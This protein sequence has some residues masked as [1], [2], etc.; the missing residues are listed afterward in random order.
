MR[1]IKKYSESKTHNEI[2][3]LCDKYDI[4]NYTINEDGSIDVDG[5]VS[6]HGNRLKELPLTFNKVSGDFNISINKLTSLEG[7]PKYVG[8]DFRCVSNKLTSLKY[9]PKYVG[10]NFNC[11][12]NF[13]TSLDSYPDYVGGIFSCTDN[14]ISYIYRNFIKS[15]DNIEL[16]NEFKIIIG[17]NLY[18]N[19]LNAYM[20]TNNIEND[21]TIEIPYY[22]I[23]K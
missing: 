8:V 11:V 15:V 3:V 4:E 20:S 17:D 6:L 16:F 23:I 21:I 2:K 18:A 10:S 19:R 22:K 5:D 13:I 14:P 1:Y 9:C 12:D 7:A